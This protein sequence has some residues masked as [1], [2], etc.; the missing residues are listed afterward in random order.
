MGYKYQIHMHT[1]PCSGCARISMA[2]AVKA[3]YAGG[4]AGGVIT[5]HFYHGNTGIDRTLDWRSFVNAYELDYL[6]GKAEAEKL[7]MNIIFGIEEHIGEGREILPYGITP[8]M[9]YAHPEIREP[10]NGDFLTLW[11]TLADKYG[12][13]IIQA[14]PTRHRD[15]IKNPTMLATDFIDGIEAYNVGNTCEDN[16]TSAALTEAYPEMLVTSGGD[17]HSQD[18]MCF[19]GIETEKIIT[20]TYELVEVLRSGK[21][22]IIR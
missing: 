20:S 11:R 10:Q 22:T 21:Y 6:D 16:E 3:L 19:G 8:E 5:N 9:L 14:H 13:L 18:K 2:D 7:G 4:Y 1:Q 15:Y 12:F 17:A